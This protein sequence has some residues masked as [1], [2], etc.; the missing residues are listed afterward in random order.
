MKTSRSSS[1][2]RS[3]TTVA[4][5]VGVVLVGHLLR[6]IGL[7]PLWEEAARN[8]LAEERGSVVT[9]VQRRE[10]FPG[11]G[12]LVQLAVRKLLHVA[13]YEVGEHI[14]R[15]VVQE[16]VVWVTAVHVDGSC[17]GLRAPPPFDFSFELLEGGGAFLLA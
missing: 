3:G 4:D 17:R 5:L 10:P 15:A 11:E 13:G 2:R 7:R 14:R 6:E 8:G 9:A 1:A 12:D 16:P